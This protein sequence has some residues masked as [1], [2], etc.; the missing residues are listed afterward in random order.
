MIRHLFRDRRGATA[1]EFALVAPAMLAM[2]FLLLEGGR[3][4]WTQQVLQETAFAAARCMALKSSDC[5]DVSAMPAW[6]VTRARASGVRIAAGAVHIESN[7]ASNNPLCQNQLGMNGVAI[8][9]PFASRIRHILPVAGHGLTA[10][11]CFPVAPT[12]SA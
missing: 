5:T 3:M 11:A 2:I 6:A 10:S 12:P 4:I 9:S 7:A 8:T 1:V